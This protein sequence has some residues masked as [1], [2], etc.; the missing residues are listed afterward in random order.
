MPTQP[1]APR[2]L[3]SLALLLLRCLLRVL[4]TINVPLLPC[5]ASATPGTM[6]ASL[7][8]ADARA[9]P[10]LPAF[11]RLL[12]LLRPLLP[13][14]PIPFLVLCPFAGIQ[15]APGPSLGP[16]G[17]GPSISDPASF[18]PPRPDSS[19]PDLGRG[20]GPDATISAPGHNGRAPM[21]RPFTMP[22]VRR[23]PRASPPM[24]WRSRKVS[25]TLRPTSKF[26][27]T[28][29]LMLRRLSRVRSAIC[30]ITSRLS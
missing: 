7:P 2:M 4:R 9:L 18:R 13:S 15:R 6:Y 16:D 23:H 11:L 1:A 12:L 22:S 19:G 3:R 30:G 27:A 17:H 28:E 10:A 25:L 29:F 14:R 5:A 24:F 8:A 26:F 21:G 20:D